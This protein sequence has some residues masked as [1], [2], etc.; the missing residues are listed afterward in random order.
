MT[1][2]KGPKPANPNLR[3]QERPPRARLIPS[4]R[5]KET[6][7]GERWVSGRV[8]VSPA[9]LGVS[10]ERSF[11]TRRVLRILKGRDARCVARRAGCPPYPKP[12][13]RPSGVSLFLKVGIIRRSAT[14]PFGSDRGLKSTA[15]G[16]DRSAVK[17]SVTLIPK[18]Y[19]SSYFGMARRPSG[20]GVGGCAFPVADA[21][22]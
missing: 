1:L 10:P 12:S 16:G 8:G 19:T 20:A 2:P 7:G 9:G 21:T 17:S 22:G 13:H 3:S 14:H 11:G 5:N 4:F 6:A 18:H 15:T